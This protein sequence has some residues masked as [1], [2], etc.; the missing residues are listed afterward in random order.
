ME[1]PSMPKPSSKLASLNCSMG[2]ETWCQRPGRSVKRRSSTLISCFFTNS[3]TS[4]G[5]P[6]RTFLLCRR[7]AAVS[8]SLAGY[9]EISAKTGTLQSIAGGHRSCEIESFYGWDNAHLFLPKQ[10]GCSLLDGGKG[11]LYFRILVEIDSFEAD[12]H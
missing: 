7:A 2:N 9:L 1:E 6:I 11:R 3:M 4:L 8:C 5:V 10:C 12:R